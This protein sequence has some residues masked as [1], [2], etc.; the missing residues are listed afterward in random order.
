MVFPEL[1]RQ[2]ALSEFLYVDDLVLIIEI[3]DGTNL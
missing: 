2:G 1:A 3:N